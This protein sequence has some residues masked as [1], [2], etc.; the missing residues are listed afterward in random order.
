M[1]RIVVRFAKLAIV[2]ATMLCS[3]PVLAQIDRSSRQNNSTGEESVARRPNVLL[4]LLDDV[5][6][7]DPSTFGGAI[8]TPALQQLAQQ[9]LRYTN[10]N[11]ASMC[12]PTRAALLTGRNHHQVGF[13]RIANL[14][15]PD[16]GYSTVWP[17][18]TASIARVL[19][20][21]GYST[22]AFG[23]WHNTP[24]WEISP[25]GPFERWPTGLGFE[26][27]Y[28]F[29]A[30][31]QD[32]WQPKM[33]YRGTT[34][35][36]MPQRAGAAI[37]L[38]TALSDEAIRWI[39][40]HTGLAP[41]TPWFVYFA[42][43]AAHWPH[44]A[45]Q[46]YIERYR[47]HFDQGW[48]V[49]RKQIF[50]RQK[51]LGIVPPNTSLTARPAGLPAWSSLGADEKQLY[52]RQMEVYAGYLSHADEQIG[53]LMA[54]IDTLGISR[55]TLV[56]YI[57][58]DNGPSGEFG[59]AGLDHLGSI[60]ERLK[61]A[62]QLGLTSDIVNHYSYGWAWAGAT[63]FPGTKSI[64]SHLGSLRAPM[65][66]KWPARIGRS[67][68]RAEFAHVID[69]APTIYEA[70]RIAIP[71][72]VDGVTQIPL[73]GVSLVPSF[74][75]SDDSLNHRN[76]YFEMLGNRALFSDGWLASLRIHDLIN[77]WSSKSPASSGADWELY[78]LRSDFSQSHDVANQHRKRLQ[79]MTEIFSQEALKNSVE[80]I[81]EDPVEWGTTDAL[82]NNASLSGR[83]GYLMVYPDADRV[84]ERAIAVDDRPYTIDVV[85]EIFR[86]VTAS[87]NLVALCRSCDLFPAKIF[88]S[89]DGQQVAL[90]Y[91]D[92]GT[93][94]ALS[95]PVRLGRNE[96]KFEISHA[97]GDRWVSTFIVNGHRFGEID[98]AGARGGFSIMPDARVTTRGYR[99][100]SVSI[101]AQAPPNADLA[102]P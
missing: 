62:D 43:G 35:I 79:G 46:A 6:F 55:D 48:D 14:A 39:R 82:P 94:R 96:L 41:N 13:G 81:F 65:V 24:E 60:P 80:P 70:A 74:Q 69:I 3:V 63:P 76:Q 84:P 66:I 100:I 32:Q 10:F 71:T 53:R 49:L 51:Q 58:G 19:R 72:E 97:T 95:A 91:L 20:G 16:E 42:P 2:T 47:G 101:A 28:G 9:G 102:S 34:P 5:G 40:T 21:A 75:H 67:G 36:D 88:L 38:T 50:E 87:A 93:R 99:L 26:S 8:T 77:I 4:V 30:G 17:R 98:I 44:Q 25:V 37:H 86:S 23:K 89:I 11:T 90:N 52:A 61:R 1:I 22:A 59:V 31:A 45:P 83:A 85:L 92:K 27:F 7:A 73:A 54:A 29:M 12:S 56:I 33:L 64:A 15:S 68:I 57:G 18:R 78:D